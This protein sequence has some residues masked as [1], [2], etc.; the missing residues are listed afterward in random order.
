LR[1]DKTD[2]KRDFVYAFQLKGGIYVPVRKGD[3]EGQLESMVEGGDLPWYIDRKIAF[4]SLTADADLAVD[5]KEFEEIYQHLRYTFAN[6]FSVAPGQLKEQIDK[7][8]Y[9]NGQENINIP[10]FEKRQRLVIILEN[11]I[12]SWLDASTPLPERK[13]SLKRIDCRITAEAQCKDRCVWKGNQD[14]CLLHIPENFDVGANKVSAAKLLIRKLIEELIR[15]P[16]KRMELL[17]QNVGQYVKIMAAFRSG[18]QYIVSED[19]P[20]WSEMLR[21]EWAKKEDYKHLEEYTSIRPQGTKVLPAV[22]E[23]PAKA[24]DALDAKAPD[25]EVLEVLEAPE[26]PEAPEALEAL[27]E[28]LEAPLE[29]NIPKLVAQELIAS[30]E[31]PYLNAKFGP[32]FIFNFYQNNSM[33]PILYEFGISLDAIKEMGQGFDDPITDMNIAT[34]ISKTLN[35]SLYI[36]SYEPGNPIPP[37]PLIVKLASIE[38]K[39]KKAEFIII[40]S[41]PDGRL[42]NLFLKNSDR[43]TVPYEFLPLNIK[44]EINRVETTNPIE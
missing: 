13:P 14:K 21:M 24:P 28:V 26:V 37:T 43:K 9:F 3:E 32:K 22:P 23:A 7:I 18:S 35:L 39:R 15:F 1:L 11:T 6:W 38:N 10:L 16:V 8:I 20:A 41:L 4:G 42:G 2:P 30:S 33:V 17:T 36:L 40:V 5:Y 25:A 31:D 29:N 34:E 44:A 19:L 12:M 27:P